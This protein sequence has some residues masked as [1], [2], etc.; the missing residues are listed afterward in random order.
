MAE[1]D[2]P[3]YIDYIL[4]YTN[5]QQLYYIGHSMGT[6]MAFAMLST[7]TEYNDKVSSSRNK[8]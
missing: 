6:T 7:K 3:A 2:T 8:I 5:Y 1:F 4:N